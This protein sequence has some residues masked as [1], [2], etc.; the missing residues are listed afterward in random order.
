YGYGNSPYFLVENAWRPDNPNA[1]FPRLTA[2]KASI[3]AHNAHKNC[4]WVRK[5]NYL[6]LKSVQIGYSLPKKWI[7]GA[8]L[9]QVRLQATGSNLFTF[10][11]LKYLDPEIP[12]VNNGFY[13]QQRIFAFGVNVTF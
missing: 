12:N 13:P 11:H 9:Q 8:K 1:E 2:Y 6:R 4:G 3:S 10:D 5:G 7:E